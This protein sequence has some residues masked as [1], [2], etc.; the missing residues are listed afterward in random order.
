MSPEQ[1]P[2]RASDVRERNEKLVLRLI[3]GS[4]DRGFSQSEAVAATGLKAPTIFRIF[5][6]LEAAGYIELAPQGAAEAVPAGR[7][8]RKG[9]RPASYLAR[10]EACVLVG[11]E[12]WAGSLSLGVFDFRGRALY[13]KVFP[14]DP[15]QGA[16]KVLA[17]VAARVSKALAGLGIATERVL[18]LGLGA[19]G[20]VD[21]GR[22]AVSFYARIPGMT[23]FPAA[24]RLES[25][26]GLPVTIH[27]NCSVVA[28]SEFRHGDLGEEDST[29]MFL[30]RSGVN[31]AFVDSGRLHLTSRG[32]TIETGHLSVS[33]DGPDCPCGSRGCLEAR[34]CALDRGN[35]DAG[36]WLFEGLGPELAA[37]GKRAAAAAS[38]LDEASA[39][40]ASA[41]RTVSRLFEPASYLF[42]AASAEVAEGLASRVRA[43]IA[44]AGSGFDRVLPAFHGRAY[45]PALAQRGAADL[46]L[47]AFFLA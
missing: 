15:A 35:L 46:V 9:R 22:R 7:S 31:G 39:S 2:L 19:P 12:F 13:S 34:L 36:R 28:L 11:V 1:N 44:E 37:G 30:L 24:E 26:L 10:A 17:T 43:R 18:G 25:R 16:E 32:R 38:V 21:V 5:S 45:D 20:Q 33:L 47:D 23:D 14:L 4:G 41:A 8:E 42:V 29:F 6:S 3:H 40:L 27:N